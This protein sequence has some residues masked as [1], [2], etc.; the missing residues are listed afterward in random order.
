MV[1]RRVLGVAGFGLLG[2]AALFL[3]RDA[4]VHPAWLLAGGG[5]VAAALTLRRGAAG[6]QVLSALALVATVAVEVAAYAAFREPVVLVALGLTGAAAV[7]AARRAPLPSTAQE[8]LRS[9]AVWGALAVAV[10]GLSGGVY[11][12]L[13]TLRLWS[14]EP[15]RRLVLSLGWL[16]SGVVFL[17]LA[18]RTQ[19]LAARDAGFFMLAVT[20]A[21]VLAYDTTHLAGAARVGLLAGA[22]VLLLGAAAVLPKLRPAAERA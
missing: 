8:R 5:A 6:W 20:A 7:V 18:R 9:L 19:V 11:F 14:D 15:T 22:G 4:Q 13:L 21:K 16:V 1:D 12:E 17:A 3:W 10:L 2:L